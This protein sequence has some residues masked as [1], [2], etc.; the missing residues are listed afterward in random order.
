MGSY[1][2]SN[3]GSGNRICISKVLSSLNHWAVSLALVLTVIPYHRQ[4]KLRQEL[5][6]PSRLW[7]D[8]IKDGNSIMLERL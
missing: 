1:K 7:T 3:V 4:H 8:E 2:L 5:P 6:W